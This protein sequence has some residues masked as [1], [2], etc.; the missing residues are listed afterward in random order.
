[1]ADDKLVHTKEV[2]AELQQFVST[3][4]GRLVLSLHLATALRLAGIE[5][6]LHPG[7]Y[8]YHGHYWRFQHSDPAEKEHRL[9][10]LLDHVY[11]Q[12]RL[13]W[14]VVHGDVVLYETHPTHAN[15]YMPLLQ[16]FNTLNFNGSYGNLGYLQNGMGNFG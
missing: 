8:W 10:D 2:H 11:N 13:A 5:V 15:S 6:M 1:L 16:S 12:W 14:H 3:V 9:V 4:R 7:Q